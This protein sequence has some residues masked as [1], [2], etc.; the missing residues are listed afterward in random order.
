MDYKI[1]NWWRFNDYF[2]C[3]VVVAHDP[4]LHL[5]LGRQ[6]HILS[7][8]ECDDGYYI[9][10]PNPAGQ[11]Q[12]AVRRTLTDILNAYEPEV[13]SRGIDPLPLPINGRVQAGEVVPPKWKPRA[14]GRPAFGVRE[15]R[16][17]PGDFM[18]VY[19]LSAQDLI[20]MRNPGIEDAP[21]FTIH[22][23]PP[24]MLSGRSQDEW[25]WEDDGE[26]G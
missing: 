8:R 11:D 21:D 25:S 1:L 20:E 3:L 18:P 2:T 24:P 26:D 23:E 19:R 7:V 4:G 16:V 12:R 22:F 15:M 6:G 13:A 17:V 14:P 5:Y 9:E 10:M